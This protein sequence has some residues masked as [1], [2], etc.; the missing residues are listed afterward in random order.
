MSYEDGTVCLLH[1]H[2]SHDLRRWKSVPKRRHKITYEHGTECSETSAHKMKYEAGTACLYVCS[3]SIEDGTQ[4]SETSVQ[5][6]PWRWNRQSFSKRRH[7]ITYEDGSVPKRRYKITYEDGPV[8]RNVG[9]KL[10]IKM[11]ECSET[12]V[13]NYL[14]RW[15]RQS[16]SKRRHK[17]TYEDG[18]VFRNVCT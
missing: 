4:C 10:P 8:F 7:K 13:Q 5:N 9:K 17:I 3:I 6:Y 2:R 1:L 14:L 16:F 18:T 12:S 11:E 15:N